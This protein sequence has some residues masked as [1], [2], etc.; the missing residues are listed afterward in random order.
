MVVSGFH[1]YQEVLA[2][3]RAF[4]EQNALHGF[5]K[6]TQVV[7]ISAFNEQLLGKQL[8]LKAYQQFY[9]KH[10]A[11]VKPLLHLQLNEPETV[12]TKQAKEVEEIDNSAET[13]PTDDTIFV[14]LNDE[15]EEVER[16]T[17]IPITTDDNS[18]PQNA[19]LK[20]SATVVKSESN[21]KAEPTNKPTIKSITKSVNT[22]KT[23]I[24]KAK[25]AVSLPQKSVN[26]VPQA[27][28][29]TPNPTTKTGIYFGDGF[30]EPTSNA[31]TNVSKATKTKE[32]RTDLDDDYYELEGF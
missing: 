20:D 24:L 15:S 14:P 6:S 16:E 2:Y 23:K 11:E 28:S 31:P 4:Y 9:K 26:S 22:A 27:N 7:L 8:S 25:K 3:A 32:K 21:T 19:P 1:N 18:L 13:T 29:K 30:G 10:F 12:V 5:L 17:I